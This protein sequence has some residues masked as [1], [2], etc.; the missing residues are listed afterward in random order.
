M[1]NVLLHKT[2]LHMHCS[3]STSKWHAGAG[4]GSTR[5]RRRIP[6]S[7]EVTEAT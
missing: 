3:L 7:G 5:W 4:R 1:M 2:L 6:R